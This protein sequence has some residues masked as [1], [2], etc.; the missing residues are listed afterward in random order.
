MAMDTFLI[1]GVSG[2]VGSSLAIQL[3]KDNHCVIGIARR[4]DFCN[5][6]QLSESKNF[7]FIQGEISLELL[8][9]L[10]DVNI[11][12][13]YHLAS[14]QPGNPNLQ[15]ADFY[16]GN[17]LTTLNLIQYFKQK[18]ID[19]F[20]YTSTI[21]VFGKNKKKTI[22]ESEIPEPVNNYGLTKYISEKILEIGSVNFPGKVLI[23]RLQSV[24]GKNDGYGVVNTF[25]KQFKNNEN[26][27][28]FSKGEIYRN[29]IQLEDSVDILVRVINNYN[30][31]DKYEIF[32]AASSNSLRTSEIASIIKKYLNSESEIVPLDKKYIYD[33]DIFVDISKAKERL[34]FEPRSLESA[35]LYCLK[36]YEN[37]L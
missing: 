31:L 17:V 22:N 19:F 8:K 13:V 30:S 7:S 12:G 33:W 15:Y 36:Q 11:K 3:L 21:S 32:Q 20:C 4:A 10:D 25:Y 35:I 16:K 14:Q 5:K 9:K 29:L 2:F 24:F 23:V 18:P 26:V 1:T 37:E 6:E 28:L 34:G 27:E